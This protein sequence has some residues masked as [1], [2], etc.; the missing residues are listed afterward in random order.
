MWR[1][2]RSGRPPYNSPADTLLS[3]ERAGRCARRLEPSWEQRK[4]GSGVSIFFR[5]FQRPA[6]AAF[7][8]ESG[9]QVHCIKRTM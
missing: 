8:C 6:R 9:P 3:R 7:D 5:H 1:S 2:W 4:E